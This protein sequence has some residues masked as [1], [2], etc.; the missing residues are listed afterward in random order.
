MRKQWV[1]LWVKWEK[2]G[3]RETSAGNNEDHIGALSGYLYR[4][5][6][7]SKMQLMKK[8]ESGV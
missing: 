1:V 5:K 7:I 3:I 4:L 8:A 2:I 6:H